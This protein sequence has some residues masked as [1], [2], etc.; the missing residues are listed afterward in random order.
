MG[1][2][3]GAKTPAGIALAIVAQIHATLGLREDSLGMKTILISESEWASTSHFFRLIVHVARRGHRDP[4]ADD[5]GHSS[6]VPKCSHATARTLSAAR[7][8]D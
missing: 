6:R 4:E 7:C 1:L 2:D 5:S 3:I 8:A